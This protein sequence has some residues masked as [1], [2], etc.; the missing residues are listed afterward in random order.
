MFHFQ[1][2]GRDGESRIGPWLNYERALHNIT[3]VAEASGAKLLLFK[4][5]NSI[6]NEKYTDEFA[7]ASTLYSVDDYSTLRNC[8]D[9]LLQNLTSSQEVGTPSLVDKMPQSLSKDVA[10]YC[11]NGAFIESGSQ[12][13]NKRLF[14]L[15][16]NARKMYI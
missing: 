15:E 5:T 6:C 9:I 10:N 13:L 11:K 8:Q 2:L 7:R 12:H 1:N 14:Q 3:L 16:E 4:T